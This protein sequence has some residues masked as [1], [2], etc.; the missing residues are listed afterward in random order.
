[1]KADNIKILW[2]VTTVNGKE[3]ITRFLVTD[4]MQ[5]DEFQ[6]TFLKS[7]GC[8]MSDW[9]ARLP[10]FLGRQFSKGFANESYEE[11]A[12]AQLISIDGMPEWYYLFLT[13]WIQKKPY[14]DSN[15]TL[16]DYVDN[17]LNIYATSEAA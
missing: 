2:D 5:D 16:L 9:P 11:K 14:C 12:I 10:L 1:M 17:S 4:K 8:C 13:G 15:P 3:K 6:K 7:D